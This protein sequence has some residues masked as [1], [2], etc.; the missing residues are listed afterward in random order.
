MT[1]LL[2][3]LNSAF[4]CSSP[5]PPEGYRTQYENDTHFSIQW[6]DGTQTNFAIESFMDVFQNTPDEP[7]YIEAGNT[8]LDVCEPRPFAFHQNGA[9]SSAG[10]IPLQFD[11]PS[12]CSYTTDDGAA[13]VL[14]LDE[15]MASWGPARASY[16]MRGRASRTAQGTTTEGNLTINFA[17]TR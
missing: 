7:F 12:T 17:D 10:D 6:D 2:I 5:I 8:N 14:T 1:V 13:W 3:A 15:G 9:V 4:A 11:G 16:T